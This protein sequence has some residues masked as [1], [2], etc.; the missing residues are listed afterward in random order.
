MPG[1]D[2]GTRMV[3]ATGS[4]LADPVWVVGVYRKLLSFDETPNQCSS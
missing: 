1:R 2:M 3:A 4:I